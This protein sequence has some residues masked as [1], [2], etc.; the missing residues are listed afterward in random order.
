MVSIDK[1]KCIGCGA[2]VED[3][4]PEN[5]FLDSGRA[6]IKGRC[7]QCGHCIAVC[8]VNAVSI[9]NYPQEGIEE[10]DKER[11]DISSDNLL[12]FI[13]FRRS[14]RH[15]KNKPVEKE[16]L[17]R[18]LEAGRYTATGS[19]MQDVSYIVVQE[20]LNEI[21]PVIWESLY[22]FA[23]ENL[24]EKGVIGAYAP[25]WIKMYED[26]KKDPL[27]DKLFFKAPVLLVVTAISPLNEVLA[28]SN[29]E[30]MANAEG[31]G[32]LFTGFIER[33]LKNSVKA[34]EML[35]INKKEIISCMLIGYPDI[36]F[37]R[38]VPRKQ[39]EISWK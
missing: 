8:P 21:K 27:N 6:E 37:R 15:Y 10:Y 28:P 34:K 17:E 36:K 35:G 2:C 16:K 25:R 19:N 20:T 1:E 7:M 5:L 22:E 9:T 3:C 29:I 38:T 33:A 32:V 12:N 13:K 26:Y 4:F 30:L 18:V 23:L 39:A 31:L 24:N 14:V 11:F